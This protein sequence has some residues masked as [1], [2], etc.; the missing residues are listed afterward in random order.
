MFYV[1]GCPKEKGAGQV[2]SLL[3]VQ[4]QANDAERGHWGL[5]SGAGRFTCLPYSH[6]GTGGDQPASP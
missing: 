5:A 1:S 3:Q 6:L 4:H 2:V